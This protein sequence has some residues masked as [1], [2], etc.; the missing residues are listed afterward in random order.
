MTVMEFDMQTWTWSKLKT[1]GKT[2]VCRSFSFEK[3]IVLISAISLKKMRTI[4]HLD[5]WLSFPC[6]RMRTYLMIVHPYTRETIMLLN[7]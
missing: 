6:F 2:P 3:N 4:F 7:F 5:G 1:Y